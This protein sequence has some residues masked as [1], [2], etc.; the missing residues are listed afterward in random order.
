MPCLFAAEVDLWGTTENLEVQPSVLRDGIYEQTVVRPHI[1]T[2]PKPPGGRLSVQTANSDSLCF[3][4]GGGL[5]S[6]PQHLQLWGALKFKL[7]EEGQNIQQHLTSF[8]K[9]WLTV[10]GKRRLVQQTSS[11][12]N[13]RGFPSGPVVRDPPANA[14]APSLVQQ[15][16]PCL[17]TTS[18]RRSYRARAR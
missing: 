11:R 15:D 9:K 3:L 17:G 4:H 1:N 14:E 2:H 6:F 16:S 5:C 13:I 7:V 18:P 10:G 8:W 12:I